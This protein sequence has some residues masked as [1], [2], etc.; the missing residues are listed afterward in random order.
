MQKLDMAEVMERKIKEIG[1]FNDEHREVFVNHLVKR[2]AAL[3]INME[4]IV[5]LLEEAGNAS[6]GQC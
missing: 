5:K 4:N 2:I 6:K 3:E 1:T